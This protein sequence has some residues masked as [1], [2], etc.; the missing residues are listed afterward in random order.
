MPLEILDKPIR[1]LDE[2]DGPREEQQSRN[3]LR[4]A[5]ADNIVSFGRRHSS[6]PVSRTACFEQLL[7]QRR[8]GWNVYT[9]PAAHATVSARS[10]PHTRKIV[11]IERQ[12]RFGFCLTRHF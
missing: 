6:R 4:I 2:F 7:S 12:I 8:H 3:T 11:R 5:F 10:A 9:R 1:K